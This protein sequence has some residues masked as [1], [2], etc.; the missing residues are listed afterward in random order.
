LKNR[1]SI[2]SPDSSDWDHYWKLQARGQKTYGYIANIYRRYII[3][4]T[5]NHY[6]AKYFDINSLL[7]HAG[8]GS[9]EVDLDVCE[10]MEIVAIDFSSHALSTYSEGHRIP[11]NLAQADIFRLPFPNETFD[12]VFNLGVMEHFNDIEMVNALIEL[13]RVIKN[14][15]VILLFW[16]PKWGLSVV[17]LKT[18]HWIASKVFNKNLNLHPAEINLLRSRSHCQDFCV[19]ANLEIVGFRFGPRDLFTHQIVALKKVS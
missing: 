12:G 4:G 17:V 1:N 5:L 13:R 7:L 16:P 3:K 10:S 19:S 9:G 11:S 8:S 2:K 14:D 15:G 6:V 18:V